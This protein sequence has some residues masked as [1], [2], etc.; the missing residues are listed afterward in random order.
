M[1]VFYVALEASNAS[2]TM[3]ILATNR[4]A[5]RLLPP[6]CDNRPAKDSQAA[7]IQRLTG[8]A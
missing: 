3:M 1:Y 2:M 8:D 4:A 6:I 7:A 5:G